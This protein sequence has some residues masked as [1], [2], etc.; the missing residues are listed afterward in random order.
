MLEENTT[1]DITSELGD[2]YDKIQAA[3][4]P[5][6]E[7]DTSTEEN[8]E[9]TNQQEEVE[10]S[11]TEETAQ[12]SETIQAPKSWS[13]EDRAKF[14]SL[15]P[16]L[17]QVVANRENDRDKFLTQ[18]SYEYS[19]N[20]TQFKELDHAFSDMEPALRSMGLNKAQ[21]AKELVALYKHYESDPVGYITQIAQSKGIDLQKL[22]S[23]QLDPRQMAL[24]QQTHKI[25]SLEQKLDS[26]FQEQEKQIESTLSQEINAFASDPANEF[27]SEVRV[28]MGKLIGSEQAKDLQEAYDM[29]VWANPATRAKLLAKQEAER[30]KNFT[31]KA[32]QAKKAA[33]PK[34][35]TQE[36]T[37]GKP[38]NGKN[39]DQVLGDKFDEIMAA[40]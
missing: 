11:E 14:A 28:H 32:K 37:G 35:Q 40:G 19:Q 33:G 3:D 10:Q 6:V 13:A 16:D 38:V 27:Y 34:L 29:A 23:G 30:V 39:I 22:V 31:T 24:Q 2:A 17:Q 9:I 5:E 18:K 8:T 15:P 7:D 1:T 26:F 21:A 12:V 4:A 25:S 20:I 36:L